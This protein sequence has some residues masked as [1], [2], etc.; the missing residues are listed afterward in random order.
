M[1]NETFLSGAIE[2]VAAPVLITDASLEHPGPSIVYINRAFERMTG[3]SAS[4]LIGQ[5]PRILQ[6]AE[7]DPEV[8]R[9][10]RQSLQ[11]GES[12][13]GVNVNYRKS[14]EPYM[15]DWEISPIRNDQGVVTHYFSIQ[16]EIS[17]SVELA[18]IGETIMGVIADGV[19]GMDG[20]GRIQ[21][22]N[23]A[24]VAMLG[25]ESSDQLIGRNAHELTH[26][27]YPDG[28][29]YPESECP[30]RHSIQHSK[31]LTGLDEDWLWRR[32]GT[33]FPVEISVAPS[34]PALGRELGGVMTFRDITERK[35]L[36]MRLESLAYHDA[37]TGLYNRSAFYERLEE[38]LSRADRYQHS[39]SV[40]MFDIDHFK[41]INDEFGH[42]HGDRVLQALSERVLQSLRR[43]DNLS[44]WG[45]EEFLV[46]L[47]ESETEQALQVAHKLR[48]VVAGEPFPVVGQV[49]ISLGVTGYV[50]GEPVHVFLKR[51]DEAMYDAKKGGRNR[52]CSR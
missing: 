39:V 14:G 26:Y 43:A 36:Q 19:M 31:T 8:S 45:G 20:N 17:H 16:S 13:K 48:E 40:I 10:L 38:E 22:I 6:G 18:R 25:Y 42:D 24:G 7:T 11:A 41:S 21:F 46:I 29:D 1:A 15:V 12:F 4:E 52:A 37:L 51:V 49:T 30:I 28:S 32:D 33:G 27:A 2:Q 47:P 35:D 34:W 9:R 44:R 5:T 3:Y 50:V 23:P